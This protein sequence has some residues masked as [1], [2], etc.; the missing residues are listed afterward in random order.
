MN[1]FTV[2][3]TTLP[4][5]YFM[6]SK[7]YQ[8]S[9]IAIIGSMLASVVNADLAGKGLVCTN[10]DQLSLEWSQTEAPLISSVAHWFDQERVSTSTWAR[11]ND[12]IKMLSTRNGVPFETDALSIRW[13]TTV[14]GEDRIISIDRATAKRSVLSGEIVL[15]SADCEIFIK[16]RKFKT[17]LEE[18]TKIL[19]TKFNQAISDHKL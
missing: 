9:S 19:Q 3:V 11:S 13:K 2:I 16:E 15:V 18:I 1:A 17:K 12:A 10:Q 14:K 4:L 6:K 5:Y 8:F 7:I